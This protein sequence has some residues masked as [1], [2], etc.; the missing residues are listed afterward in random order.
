MGTGGA[1][2]KN[3][4]NRGSGSFFVYVGLIAAAASVVLKAFIGWK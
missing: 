3:T 2:M 1:G 4:P